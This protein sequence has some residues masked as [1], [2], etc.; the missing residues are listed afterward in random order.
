MWSLLRP[1]VV[2]ARRWSSKQQIESTCA[3]TPLQHW[4]SARRGHPVNGSCSAEE[5]SEVLGFLR[6]AKI[7]LQASQVRVQARTLLLLLRRRKDALGDAL[8]STI[9]NRHPHHRPRIAVVLRENIWTL[10]NV[11]CWSRIAAAPYLGHLIVQHDYTP[12]LW[13]FLLAGL[14]DVADGLIARSFPGQKT[15]FGSFLDPAADKVLAACTFLPLAIVGLIPWYLA[16]VILGRDACL[17]AA[18]V[19]VRYKSLPSPVTLVR[20]F[21]ASRV[22]AQLKP[23][24]LSK[25]NTGIQVSLVIATLLAHSSMVVSL[26]DYLPHFCLI[27]RV[28]QR[29]CAAM[30]EK[31]E[32]QEELGSGQEVKTESE[33]DKAVKRET[34]ILDEKDDKQND[35]VSIAKSRIRSRIGRPEASMRRRGDLA[36]VEARE[37][38]YLDTIN[39]H[40]LDFDFEKLCSVSL[41]RI[42]VYACL[43]CGK[44]FQGRGQGTHAYTHSVAEGEHRMFLNLSTLKFYCLPDNYEIKDSSLDDIKYVLNPTFTKEAIQ[45]LDRNEKLSR[46]VDG[47]VYL[48]GIVGLNN[49]KANDYCN[50]VLQAMSHVQP[51]RDYF[52]REDNYAAVNK[53][54]GDILPTLSQRFGELLRKLWNPRNFKAHVSPHEMLQA[55]VLCS[56]KRFQITQQGDAVA[57]LTWFLNA[58]HAALGGG[59]GRRRHSSVLHRAFQGR[60]RVHTR[61]VPP[62]ELDQK[63]KDQLLQTAEYQETS[64]E[65]PFLFLTADLPP[66]PLFADAQKET[67]IPQVNFYALMSKFNGKTEK[68]YHTYKENFIKRYELVRLPRYIIICYKRFTKN[69]FFVEKNPTIVNFPIT[70]MDFGDFLSPEARKLHDT[71]TYDLLANIVHD[72]GPQAGTYRVHILHKGTGK[73]YELQDL[74]VKD[75]LPQ[76][77]TLTEAYIQLRGHTPT[78]LEG[79][80]W[81]EEEQFRREGAKFLLDL[82][83]KIG[84]VYSTVATGVVY[85]HRFYMFQSFDKFPKFVT[86]CSCLFLAGKVEETPKKCRDLIRATRELLKEKPEYEAS[87]A[88][89]LNEFGLHP[90]REIM[91]MERV[92]LQTFKFDLQ[93]DHPY[94]FLLKYVKTFASDQSRLEGLVQM[95]WTFVNDSLVTTLCLQWE[96][97][98][99][100]VA[101]IYLAVKLKKMQVEDNWWSQFVS[102]V[103]RETLDKICHLLLDVYQT[104]GH[105]SSGESRSNEFLGVRL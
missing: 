49:I 45:A 3:L 72:G 22:T 27:C 92:L 73:W 47:S 97:E 13:L 59:A 4:R 25:A 53:V 42:N 88:E 35:P 33:T 87:S 76:M 93:V 55:V 77:I 20:F 98:I 18:A 28:Y 61:R 43:V 90:E 29:H 15:Q 39:R 79:H 69:N 40:V 83:S 21:E 81:K 44:Y 9:Q 82:S 38:P 26:H 16:L 24:Y 32:E 99:L 80:T 56:K 52:L 54:P 46:S 66:P 86:A 31:K 2:L 89:I 10:P 67:I 30:H 96:P 51:V 68:E 34:D 48:P 63:A 74:H 12:A 36:V 84:L 7:R 14:S 19:Y 1:S 23:T 75:I 78:I 100:A 91:T 41:S 8:R 60:M 105:D 94:Q 57:F 85:F 70:G 103:S 62:L 11:L 50:V 95:A 17:V 6:A 101:M 64:E 104:V 37:C 71:T 58:L 102:D 5:N 65:Q